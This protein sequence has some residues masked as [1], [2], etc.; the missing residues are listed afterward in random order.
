[1]FLLPVTPSLPLTN[2]LRLSQLTVALRLMPELPISAF[3]LETV[4]SRFSEISILDESQTLNLTFTPSSDIS[5]S[6]A[7]INGIEIVSM[8]ANIYY[9]QEGGNQISSAD[10]TGMFRSWSDD[11]DYLTIANPSVNLAD[12][13]ANLT[14]SNVPSF[15]ASREI[16]PSR[17]ITRLRPGPAVPSNACLHFSLREIKT[18]TN[19][20]DKNFI[21]GRG[22]F[23]DV[24]KGFINASGSTPVAIKRSSPRSKK[25][26]LEFRTEIEMLSQLRHQNL[27]SLIGYC[28]DKDEMILVY[29]YMVHGTLRDHLYNTSKPPLPWEQ[30]LRICIGAAQGI[31][32]LHSGPNH[33]IIHRD[34]KTNILLDEKWVAKVS[35]FGLSK[36]NDMSNTHISTA[37]KGSFGYLDSEYY[38]LQRLTEKSDVYSF[39]VVLCEVLC[40]RAPIERSRDHMQISLAE[41]AQHCHNIGTLD[42]IIDPHLRSKNSSPCLSKFSEVAISCLASEGSK[43][44]AMSEVA[45]GLGLALQLQGSEVNGNY[46]NYTTNSTTVIYYHVLFTSGSGSMNVGR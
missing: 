43:R 11:I 22:A 31:H 34:V 24:Y 14:F 44:L 29:D 6:C 7:F 21:I 10:D 1:M 8:P 3:G 28:K 15:S 36:M 20:F 12:T 42:Q 35:D 18:E 32:Y 45:C 27:V 26:V 13:S 37:V 16:I 39:G 38:R 5:D 33:S 41:W 2:L 19:S 23:G 30:R 25:G 9:K 46:E 17:I 4:L 40:G